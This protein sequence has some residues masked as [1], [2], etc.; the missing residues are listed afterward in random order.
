MIFRIPSSII[1]SAFTRCKVKHSD[2]S[3][4]YLAVEHF[5]FR[6]ILLLQIG[7]NLRKM[8]KTLGAFSLLQ[9][10]TLSNRPYSLGWNQARQDAS[11]TTISFYQVVWDIYFTARCP[12]QTLTYMAN[13]LDNYTTKD[14]L[15][16]EELILAVHQ[17]DASTSQL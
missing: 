15:L 17:R 16:Y 13:A 10:Q 14:D 11:P 3:S 7:C 6:I 5:A 1:K 9:V 8:V 4:M 12:V 2:S